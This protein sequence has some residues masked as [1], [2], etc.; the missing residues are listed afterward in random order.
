MRQIIKAGQGSAFFIW[1]NRLA[2][3]ANAIGEAKPSRFTGIGSRFAAADR[4]FTGFD[5][6]PT[7]NTP[8]KIGVIR[9]NKK[10]KFF[11]K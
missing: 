3:P 11:G 4:V 6:P 1:K 5:D 2:K 7:V 10:S 9:K 8:N